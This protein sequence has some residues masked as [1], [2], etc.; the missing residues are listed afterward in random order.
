MTTFSMRQGSQ[1]WFQAR[2][3]SCTGSHA[4]DILAMLKSGKGEQKCRADY[5]LKLAT[6]ILTGIPQMDGYLSPA[7]EWGTEQEPFARAAYEMKTGAIVDAVGFV[8]HPTI[9]R[10]G[11]SPDGLIGEDGGLEIKCPN[12]ITHIRWMLDGQVPEEHQPQMF[13][14]MACTGRKW[15]DFVSFDPRLPE[16]L[17]LFIE[18]LEAIPERIAEIESAVIQ[19]N[20]EVDAVIGQLKMIAGVKEFVIPAQMQ[21]KT[22]PIED[23]ITQAD[24]DAIE[25][26]FK[27][28]E[29][30]QQ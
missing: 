12:S 9:A 10:M 17:Q 13:F 14:Y 19:F 16:P 22:A 7:M 21:A 1:E 30:T 6:E 24:I 8:T 23:G 27:K 3:G 29:R 11:G 26:D 25:A 28:Q 5:R 18:R 2:A 20:A 15:L 4:A